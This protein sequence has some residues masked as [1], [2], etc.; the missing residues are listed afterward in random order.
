MDQS[1]SIRKRVLIVDDNAQA[2]DVA[3]ELPDLY[4]YQTAV[5]YGGQEGLQAAEA[6]APDVI[7]LD[8]GMP[9]LDGFQVAAA[10]RARPDFRDVAIVAFSAWGDQGTRQR[11]RA[12]GF[13]DH[14]TK[15]ASLDE[16]V[17][18]IAAACQPCHA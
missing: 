11:T 10:L 17:S 18:T 16:I 2:A 5:A 7:L 14:L 13:N 12:A 4:G 6:F 3:S 9:G 1:P 15:P 8:L